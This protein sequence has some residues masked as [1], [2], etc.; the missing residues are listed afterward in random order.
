MLLILLNHDVLVKNHFGKL[1]LD[2]VALENS[3][4]STFFPKSYQKIF[5]RD[6]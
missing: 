3:Q 4:H 5:L 1:D 2:S 6:V